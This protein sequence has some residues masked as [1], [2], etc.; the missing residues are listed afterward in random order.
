V[1]NS[2]LN[3]ILHHLATTH[4]WRTDGRT[5]DIHDNCSTIT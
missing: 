1:I 2:N 5:D 3:L 4:S